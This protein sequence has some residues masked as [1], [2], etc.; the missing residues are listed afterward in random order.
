MP[1][2]LPALE[3]ALAKAKVSTVARRNGLMSGSAIRIV[4]PLDGVGKLEDELCAVFV[5][6]SRMEKLP[7]GRGETRHWTETIK[8]ASERADLIVAAVNA[9]PALIAELTAARSLLVE[10][11]VVVA[12][13]A[14][15]SR[16]L[17][18]MVGRGENTRHRD[19]KD[20]EPFD[21]PR[22]ITW[23]MVR[24]ALALASK[25]EAASV[26]SVPNGKGVG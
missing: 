2:D 26:S 3:A 24:A 13:F 22:C 8:L 6:R 11:G 5:E 10:A 4:G 18:I 12:P 25:L 19:A 23:G 17:P 20:S 9:L 16:L 7:Y 21:H 1:S 14:E 15:A